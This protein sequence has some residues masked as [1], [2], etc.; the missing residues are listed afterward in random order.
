MES[1]VTAAALRW[2]RALRDVDAAALGT[3]ALAGGLVLFL[4]LEGGGYDIVLRSQVGVVLWWLVLVGAAW[5][6]LPAGRLTRAG[7]TAVGLLAGFVAWTALATTWSLSSERS[8]QELSRVASYLAVLVLALAIHRDRQR[9]VRHTVHALAAAVVIVAALALLSRLFPSS[10]PA[11]HTTAAFLPGTGARLGWPLNYWNALAALVALGLPLLLSIATS[12][13]TLRG[14]AAAAGAVPVLVLC[15]YL[16]FSRG[17]AIAA[18]VA[19]LAFIALAPERFPKLAT[20]LA[21]GAGGV[22][23]VAGAVHRSAIERGLTGPATAVQ[24]RQL[25]VSIV[26]VCCGVALAQAGI[27]LAVRHGTPPRW[28]RVSP[29]RA[30]ALLSGAVVIALAAALALGAPSRLNH[31]WQQFKNPTSAALGPDSLARFGSVSGNGR[32]DYW[33]A[34]VQATSGHVIGGSGP[35]TFQ[36][37]WEPRAPYYSYVINAHSL[38]VETLAEVGVIG[39]ALL[40]GFLLLVLGIAVRLVIRS[41]HE[42]RALAAGAVAALIAFAVSASA[43]WVWQV[44]V[45]PAAFLLLA[46]AVLAPGSRSSGAR[47]NRILVR[48]GA[49]LTALA[50]LATIGIALGTA[51]SVRQSQD[52]AAAGNTTLAL[53]AAQTAAR[54]EP[55]AASAQLQEALVLELRHDL[56]DAV[57]AARRATR[58]EPANWGNWLVLSRLEAESGH[59]QAAVSAYSRARLDNPRSPVFQ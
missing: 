14:Q 15:G 58:D 42:A 17:G 38:Y 39:L 46:A 44:P 10:F 52:A 59:V 6:I 1:T 19:L 18:A 16:T 36:L 26:L 35:G 32:Y 49:I 25:L 23:L 4:G 31:A 34:A 7:W 50:C 28:L 56:P 43:D 13:R 48:A 21:T 41:E 11:A 53:A 5:G 57:A 8:L 45:L 33:T 51:S 2:P 22:I 47:R 29:A 20:V 30:R 24:G 27:G 55:G 40:L 12:A 9:A 54:L 3:W 37:L